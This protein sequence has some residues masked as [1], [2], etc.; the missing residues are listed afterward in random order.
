M[1]GD[2]SKRKTKYTHTYTYWIDRL[3]FIER[4]INAKFMFNCWIPIICINFSSLFLIFVAS[5]LIISI[6]L[7]KYIIFFSHLIFIRS[8]WF[9]CAFCFAASSSSAS[10]LVSH[11]NRIFFLCFCN[12]FIKAIYY[13]VCDLFCFVVFFFCVQS[14]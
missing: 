11:L 10:H 9:V 3:G 12:L 13:S 8:V 2:F 14:F 4:P 5:L 1:H 6:F 7:T